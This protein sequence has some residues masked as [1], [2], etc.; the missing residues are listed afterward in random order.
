MIFYQNCRNYK[1]EDCLAYNL[2]SLNSDFFN[3]WSI[4]S[5]E[6]EKTS[7]YDLSGLDF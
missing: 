3:W 6:K 1:N 2:S 7:N 4:E 5:K